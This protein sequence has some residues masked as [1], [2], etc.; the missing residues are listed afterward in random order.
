VVAGVGFAERVSGT[1]G[2]LW[3]SS[4]DMVGTV[5]MQ[6]NTAGAGTVTRRW[7]D[8]FGQARGA[9]GAWS[10]LLGYLNKPASSTGI[11]QLGARAYDASLCRFLTVDPLLDTGEPRHANG[12]VYS[13][14]SP[15]S[16]SDADGLRPIGAGDYAD[17]WT[18][19][20]QPGPQ[21]G[22]PPIATSLP[23]PQ[24][25]PSAGN[26][27]G[28]RTGSGGEWNGTP[29]PKQEVQWW[30]PLSWRMGETAN[31][32]TYGTLGCRG[33]S[34]PGK[35]DGTRGGLVNLCRAFASNKC[36]RRDLQVL[37][38]GPHNVFVENVMENFMNDNKLVRDIVNAPTSA[39]AVASSMLSGGSCQG[40]QGLLVCD[41]SP[42]AQQGGTTYGSVFLISR[43]DSIDDITDGS[44]TNVATLSHESWHASQWAAFGNA[45]FGASYVQEMA[46]SFALTGNYGRAN[47]YEFDAGP[48]E[49]LYSSPSP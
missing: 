14:N 18:R 47:W 48:V 29:K 39:V 21:T 9:G 28:G 4:P 17:P 22:M 13:F 27:G 36:E 19:P 45:S 34:G 35:A 23:S 38:L 32:C 33:T 12:Y 1:G 6:I 41:K 31:A 3:W 15:V 42:L 49:G 8:P 2:G 37:P 43:T 44:S 10:S 46:K 16:Y 30:N 11:T 40:S 7:M 24:V 5:G 20:F 25:P 26:G